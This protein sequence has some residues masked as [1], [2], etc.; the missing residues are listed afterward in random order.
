MGRCPLRVGLTSGRPCTLRPC[1]GATA[2][3]RCCLLTV[4]MKRVQYSGK[5]GS[6]TRREGVRLHASAKVLQ[7]AS[8][9]PPGLTCSA[10]GRVSPQ[11]RC[12]ASSFKDG[13]GQSMDRAS[14]CND[15]SAS[16]VVKVTDTCPWCAGDTGGKAQC[17]LLGA[18]G[19]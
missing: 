12:D 6:R 16:V 15:V 19:L 17:V 18:G 8:A 3:R 5:S 11:V 1:P 13:Y 2:A 4:V 14:V 10:A 7:H 9:G